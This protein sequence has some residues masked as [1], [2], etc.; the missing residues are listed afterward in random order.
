M[1]SWDVGF[2]N[3]QLTE[4]GVASELCFFHGI[5]EWL[6]VKGTLKIIPCMDTSHCPRI[7]WPEGFGMCCVLLLLQHWQVVS[8]CS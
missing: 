8:G 3:W 5:L 1:V 4:V 6:R 2:Q 7:V